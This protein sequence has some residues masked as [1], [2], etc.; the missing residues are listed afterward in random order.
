VTG[1]LL[2]EAPLLEGRDPPQALKVIKK[3]RPTIDCVIFMV[4]ILYKKMLGYLSLNLY[5][6]TLS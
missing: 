2:E 4:R 1:L 6:E 5:I 3:T